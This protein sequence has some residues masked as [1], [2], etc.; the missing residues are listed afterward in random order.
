MA[1]RIRHQ[2]RMRQK[3]ERLLE[4]TKIEEWNELER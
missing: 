4:E 3:M 2:R 1:F